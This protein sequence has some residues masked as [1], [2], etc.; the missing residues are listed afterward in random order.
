MTA[1]PWSERHATEMWAAAAFLPPLLAGLASMGRP[2]V[3]D[4][5]AVLVLVLV[6]A[7]I[8]AVGPSAAG[9]GAAVTAAVAFD[10]FWTE[11]FGS[12]AIDDA[13]DVITVAL[14]LL[15]AVASGQLSM[16]VTRQQATAAQQ[17]SY[18]AAVQTAVTTRSASEAPDDS[19]EAV[20]EAI[21]AVLGVDRC[22]LVRGGTPGT[23]R[24]GA[25]GD[26][27]QSG[28]TLDV[29]RRGLP[30]DD[31]IVLPVGGAAEATVRFEVSAASQVAHPTLEQRQ[32]AALIARLVGAGLP[33]LH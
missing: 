11:P 6:V 14:L 1:Q 25:D 5:H 15:V 17:R 4:S 21:T 32:V 23:T 2:V 13:S 33:T 18:L 31:V 20:C 26:V 8:S 12:L 3:V 9:V 28:R 10:Y 7:L 24:L 19:L 22:R 29:A 16:W 30:T 27:T